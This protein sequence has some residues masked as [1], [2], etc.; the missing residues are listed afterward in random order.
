MLITF[1]SSPACER[2]AA[3]WVTREKPQ[4]NIKMCFI[5]P[6]YS[7]EILYV[8]ALFHLFRP[9]TIPSYLFCISE[10]HSSTSVSSPN[11][12]VSLALE[13]SRLSSLLDTAFW[14]ENKASEEKN[15]FEKS[16]KNLLVEMGN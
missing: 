13:T 12:P 3:E 14:K 2:G 10:H 4:W 5:S 9:T 16:I 1:D 8:L 11:N 6:F 7:I 15:S